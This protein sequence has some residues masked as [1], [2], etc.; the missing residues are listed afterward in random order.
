[1]STF[2]DIIT[3][4][5]LGFKYGPTIRAGIVEA[6]NN[7]KIVAAIAAG[8]AA[9]Q[10]FHALTATGPVAAADPLPSIAA[11]DA[12]AELQKDVQVGPRPEGPGLGANV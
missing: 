1:M 7:P 4:A 9:L 6:N 3:G 8:Y 12:I 5:R 10:E 2:S 11:A